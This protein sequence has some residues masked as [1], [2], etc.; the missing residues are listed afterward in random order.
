MYAIIK[1]GGKQYR[2]GVGD[3]IDVENLGVEQGAKLSLMRFSLSMT[4]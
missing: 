1:T 3:V 4:R 2:V